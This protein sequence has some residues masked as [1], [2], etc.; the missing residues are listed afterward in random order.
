MVF[1]KLGEPGRHRRLLRSQGEIIQ[2]QIAKDDGKRLLQRR[3]DERLVAELLIDCLQGRYKDVLFQG[4]GCHAGKVGPCHYT[5][6][7]SD[8]C[9]AISSGFRFALRPA[10]FTF[11]SRSLRRRTPVKETSKMLSNCFD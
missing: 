1:A 11:S 2:G 8:N 9:A 4:L 6:C 10:A 7:L 3:L 5:L